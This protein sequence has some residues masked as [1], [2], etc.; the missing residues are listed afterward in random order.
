MLFEFVLLLL[1]LAWNKILFPV[2]CCYV[3]SIICQLTKSFNKNFV[4]VN[5]SLNERV[6]NINQK[7][8][9]KYIPLRSLSSNSSLGV[10]TT[11]TAFVELLIN[12]NVK[13]VNFLINNEELM[14]KTYNF[15][16]FVQF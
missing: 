15:S 1:L 3:T 9:L 8:A 2:S 12:Q 14:N 4:G 16:I 10:N 11:Y 7:S 5:F 13:K 6:Q